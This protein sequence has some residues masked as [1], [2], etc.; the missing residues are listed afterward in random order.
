MT[1][2]EVGFLLIGLFLGYMLGNMAGEE[3]AMNSFRIRNRP[4]RRR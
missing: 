2:A 4:R 3:R 1:L